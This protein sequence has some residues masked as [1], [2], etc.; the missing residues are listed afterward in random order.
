MLR[1]HIID[2]YQPLMSGSQPPSLKDLK[3]AN[4]QSISSIIDDNLSLLQRNSSSSL[5][6][7]AKDSDDDKKKEYVTPT[8]VLGPCDILCGRTSAAF[9]NVGNRRF[10]AVINQHM[11]RYRGALTRHD[12]SMVIHEVLQILKDDMGARFLK[13]GKNGS[14]VEMDEKQV[15]EKVGHALRDLAA[16]QSADEATINAV[17]STSKR[18]TAESALR[19]MSRTSSVTSASTA[20]ASTVGA[21]AVVSSSTTA[22]SASTANASIASD[23]AVLS[24][25]TMTSNDAHAVGKVAENIIQEQ[26]QQDDSLGNLLNSIM[27]S[28][29]DEE[30]ND[31]SLDPLPINWPTGSGNNNNNNNQGFP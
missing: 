24:S 25:S 29:G 16:Q 18:F 15:R 28:I 17:V 4:E 5:K 8:N 13:V 2:Y 12:R 10:R 6:A 22:A 9:N 3:E 14:Y 26:K 20:S 23:P 21:A 30:S 31:Q 19:A 27:E 1:A 7:E 11:H